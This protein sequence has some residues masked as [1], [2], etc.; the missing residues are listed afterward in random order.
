MVC[1]F[2]KVQSQVKNKDR[3][4]PSMFISEKQRQLYTAFVREERAIVIETLVII[5]WRDVTVSSG[6]FM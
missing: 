1:G 5:R 6:P 2:A 4:R 3:E